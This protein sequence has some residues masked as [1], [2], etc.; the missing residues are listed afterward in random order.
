MAG[1]LHVINPNSSDH[2]TEAIRHA[3]RPYAGGAVEI[4]IT[5]MA[6]GPKGIETEADLHASVGPMLRF[7]RSEPDAAGFVIACFGDPGLHV[8]REVSGKPVFG[9]GECGVLS[10]LA[11]GDRFGVISILEAAIPRHL[12]A[13]RVMG[14]MNRLVA[15]RAIGMGVAALR[16]KRVM[17]EK[18]IA[19]GQQLTQEDGADVIL[20]AGAAMSAIR[21]DI[22][23]EIGVPVV[24]PTAAAIAMA[25]GLVIEIDR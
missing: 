5:S 11:L 9:I 2:V 7:V 24:D 23:R 12:R 3:A 8:L 18:M 13:F 25:S 16:D 17:L 22:E 10:A 6:D 20:L 21:S 1:I 19:T 4:A 15:D 14:V